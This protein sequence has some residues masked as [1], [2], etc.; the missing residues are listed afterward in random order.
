MSAVSRPLGCYTHRTAIS[1]ER[2]RAVS[3]REVAFTLR[4]DDKGGKRLVRLD[5]VEFVRRFLA[6]V[7]PT[8]VKRIRHYGVLA[9]GS[10]AVKL[11]AARLAL[12]MPG[13]NAQGLESAQ[14]FIARVAKLDVGLCPCCKVARLHVTAVL[15]VQARLPT[16]AGVVAQQSRRPP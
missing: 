5:G 16:P 1:N 4:G 15:P 3:E 10:K 13:A 7:L 8:G 14:G 6:H 9:S 11:N 12:Q 2:I